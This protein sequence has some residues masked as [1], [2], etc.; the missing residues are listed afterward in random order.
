MKAFSLIELLVVISIMGILAL[1]VFPNFTSL[2]QGSK[3]AEAKT[4][5]AS[6]ARSEQAY[7]FKTGEYTD[8]LDELGFYFEPSFYVIGFGKT[9]TS[10]PPNIYRGP[11]EI[12]RVAP[13]SDD[14]ELKLSKDKFF[15]SSSNNEK[16][17]NFRIT[18]R[19]CLRQFKDFQIKCQDDNA[20]VSP[21]VCL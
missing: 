2:K 1:V 14:C 3:S 12:A 20:I 16:L 15:A 18:E 11:N 17:T 8:D 6:L 4:G 9:N 21:R 13:I 7:F 5:L 19:G 10:P